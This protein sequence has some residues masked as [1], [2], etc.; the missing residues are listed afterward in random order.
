MH[1]C[2]YA[3]ALILASL[4]CLTLSIKKEMVDYNSNNNNFSPINQQYA[5]NRVKFNAT[6]ILDNLLLN[7]DAHV[8]PGTKPT[9]VEVNIFVRSMSKISEVDSEFTFDC[10]FRQSW[11]DMRLSWS[12]KNGPELIVASIKMLDKIWQPYTFF[13]NSNIAYVNRIKNLFNLK[14]QNFCNTL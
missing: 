10:Y 12:H 9:V 1:H 6:L 4:A 8:R 7:Y 14:A 5:K 13:L 3:V 2:I 11:N